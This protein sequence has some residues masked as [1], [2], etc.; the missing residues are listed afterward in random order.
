MPHIVFRGVNV[1]QLKK[2]SEPLAEELADICDCET[3]NFTFELPV[4]VSVFRGRE[5]EP[6]PLIEVKWFERGEIIRD[7][8]AVAIT[9]RLMDLGIPEVEVAFSSYSENAYYINGKSC[10][11]A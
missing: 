1:Q 11:E 3:D 6:F 10:G 8:A 5:I 7:R 2:I 4:V 9:K